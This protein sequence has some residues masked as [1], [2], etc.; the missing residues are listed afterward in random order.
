MGKT[1]SKQKKADIGRF[2][3]VHHGKNEIKVNNEA[4]GMGLECKGTKLKSLSKWK[5]LFKK[6]DAIWQK[7]DLEEESDCIDWEAGLRK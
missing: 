6:V 1:R 7:Q 3:I 5:R 2:T 4:M